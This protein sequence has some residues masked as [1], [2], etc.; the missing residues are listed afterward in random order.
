MQVQDLDA[1]GRVL[2][3]CGKRRKMAYVRAYGR[4][5]SRYTS[6]MHLGMYLG[7]HHE[8]RGGR[9]KELGDLEEGL[10]TSGEESLR[11]KEEGLRNKNF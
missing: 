9:L 11:N 4:T 10:R 2:N 7:M 1:V 6:R 5:P 8:L 3:L